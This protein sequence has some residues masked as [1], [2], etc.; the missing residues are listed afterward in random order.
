MAFMAHE[1]IANPDIQRKLQA[2][3][4]ELNKSLGGK[5]VN[6]EQIQGMKYMDQVVCEVLRMW[7]AAPMVDRLCVKDY[8]FDYDDIKFTME[9]DLNFYIPIYGIHHDENYF[10]NPKKFDPERF[11]AENRD[12]IDP[13]TY[14]P[15]G[16]GPR[17]CIGSRFALMEI[18]TIIYYL[19]L[20]FDFEVTSKTQIPIKLSSNPTQLQTEKGV[21]VGFKPRTH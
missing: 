12:T 19:L 8:E 15:F 7:P 3:I 10:P 18:K 2:E 20:T 9:K 6:Y 21:W 14:L 13:D 16:I 5:K 11:S 17:N 4:D 1:L